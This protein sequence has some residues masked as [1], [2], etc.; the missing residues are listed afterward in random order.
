M[1]SG[2]S[3]DTAR[4]RS[5]QGSLEGV[6]KLPTVQR[7]RMTEWLMGRAMGRHPAAPRVDLETWRVLP[8]L[9]EGHG[10]ACQLEPGLA[11][12]LPE[13]LGEG[14]QA[15]LL[16][17]LT[18]AVSRCRARDRRL[19][20]EAERLGR[21][22]DD[23]GLRWRFLKGAWLAPRCY[24][25]P[26]CRPR[27]DIDLWVAPADRPRAE[28]TLAGLGYQPE[29][30]SWK[31]RRWLQPGNRRPVDWRGE[32]PDNPRPVELH[33]RVVES[34]RG[35]DFDLSP[36]R[37]AEPET[38][39]WVAGVDEATWQ[40]ALLAAHATVD[41]LSRRLR[42]IQLLDLQRLAARIDPAGWQALAALAGRP[43]QARFLWPAMALAER[44]GEIRAPVG[45]LEVL[46]MQTSPALRAWLADSDLDALG[47]FGRGDRRRELLEIPR[48]WPESAGERRLLWR[49]VLWPS[50]WQLAD[51]HPQ[52][53]ASPAW[54]LLYPLHLGY[55]LRV[56]AGRLRSR[57]LPERGRPSHTLAPRS[58]GARGEGS[59]P[60]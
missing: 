1:Q 52:L 50:R 16:A 14:L 60:R 36:V 57:S 58:P 3:P 30:R 55:S 18:D 40:L 4:G 46:S 32:H 7:V 34:F 39:A 54:P 37:A 53:A 20:A 8:A 49:A 43:G 29:S 26:D 51:R 11:D 33:P 44:Y 23:Q 48:I 15:E 47:R 56:L 12:R 5:G 41:V 13:D 21:A 22:L 2:R 24:P 59:E 28:S 19:R 38:E 45:W 27:A 6:A 35:I 42:G 31:H 9:A 17:E 25:E 10:L